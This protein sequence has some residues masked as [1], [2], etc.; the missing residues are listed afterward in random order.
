MRNVIICLL[1]AGLAAVAMGKACDFDY[2]CPK[3][4]FCAHQTCYRLPPPSSTTTTRGTWRPTRPYPPTRLY[5]G[6]R[7]TSQRP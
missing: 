4:F 2:Q 3:N 7:A 6:G 1:F 5:P